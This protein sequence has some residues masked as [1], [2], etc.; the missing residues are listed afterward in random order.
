[1]TSQKATDG[2]PESTPLPAVFKLMGERA[3][4]ALN[5]YTAEAGMGIVCQSAWPCEYVVV[6]T[7]NFAVI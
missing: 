5:T 1:M 6:A 2:H 7:H 3:T 4:A